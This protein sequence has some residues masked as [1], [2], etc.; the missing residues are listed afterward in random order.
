M[1]SLFSVLQARQNEGK[2]SMLVMIVDSGGSSPRKAGAYMVV[3]EE[4]ILLG[5]IG[6]G[7]LEY[8][9]MMRARNLL[10]EKK[11][12]Q[13]KYE[14]SNHG[15]AELGMVCGGWARVLFCRIS[16]ESEE[17]R[18]LVCRGMEAAAR[19]EPCWLLLPF[20]EGRVKLLEMPEADLG[21]RSFILEGQNYFGQPFY[22]EGRVYIFGGGHVAVETVALLSHLGFRC[23]VAD[24]REEFADPQRFPEAEDTVLVDF[25]KLEDFFHLSGAD[26]AVIMTRGH[27]CDTDAERFAL[28]S[29]VGYIGVMGSRKK[30]EFVR[31]KLEAEGFSRDQ[32]DRVIT[33][34]GIAI[35]AETPAEIAV[36][37]AGQLI[38]YRNGRR[39]KIRPEK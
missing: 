7:N 32:L 10:G 24:D 35:Q 6:G 15:A 36:S 2:D 11:N 20:G 28:S 21:Q 23:V 1:E 33:P 16:G 5:T 18:E 29:P 30:A 9:A 31:K 19:Q 39:K 3:G 38:A 27:L 13:M 8:Q 26:A 37:I 14:L 22:Y 4:G 34:I 12:D 25:S 17:D